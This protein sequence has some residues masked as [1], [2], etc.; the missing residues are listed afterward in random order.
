MNEDFQQTR[1]RGLFSALRTSFL[2]GLV[3]VLPIGLTIYIV[4][5]FVGWIDAWVL[6]LIPHAYQ[7]DTLI[8]D[9]FGPDAE[10]TPRGLGVIIFF[11]FTIIIGW[12]AKGMF[13]RALIRPAERLVERMPIVRSVYT[14][15]KQF[16]ETVFSQTGS[17]F[18]RACLLR[19]PHGESWAIGFIA[20]SAKGEVA[21]RLPTQGELLTVFVPTGL[22]PP[23]G[24][25]IF[26]P[27]S[28]VM[29]LDMKVEDAAKLIISAGLVYPNRKDPTKPPAPLP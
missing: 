4:W 21:A 14:G 11:V 28:D 8:K 10:Y 18:E 16:A 19:F 22:V 3:V 7:P 27:Q 29:I 26:V 23:T 9:Y 2:T 17:N 1:R 5:T 15:L 25:L 13:G 24:F 12:I 20:A 6:P